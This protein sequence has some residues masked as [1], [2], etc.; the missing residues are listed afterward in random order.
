MKKTDTKKTHAIVS[1]TSFSGQSLYWPVH[2]AKLEFI[3]TL[4]KFPLWDTNFV[5]VGIDIHLRKNKIWHIR[6]G[7]KILSIRIGT[8][9]KAKNEGQS[10]PHLHGINKLLNAKFAMS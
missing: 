10:F 6:S 1:L 3:S 7:Q 8:F 9:L 2:F 5:Y 4:G